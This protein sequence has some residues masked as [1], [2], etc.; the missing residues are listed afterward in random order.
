MTFTFEEIRHTQ[1]HFVCPFFI[2]SVQDSV[3]SFLFTYSTLILICSSALSRFCFNFHL[4]FPFTFFVHFLVT[5]A[6]AH[7]CESK[8]DF[9]LF[10]PFQQRKRFAFLE[11]KFEAVLCYKKPSTSLKFHFLKWVF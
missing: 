8:F 10:Q 5:G 6:S 3:Q 4:V 7:C 2:S 1:S 9:L 11:I